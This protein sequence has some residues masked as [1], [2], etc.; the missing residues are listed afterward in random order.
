MISSAFLLAV[1]IKNHL[2]KAAAPIAHQLADNMYADNMITGIANI[3]QTHADELYKGAKNLFQSA[4]MNYREWAPEYPRMSSN[5]CR[6]NESPRYLLEFD[7]RCQF[8]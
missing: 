7:H 8:Y 2:T 5:Q 1:P 6:N 3:K 4:L